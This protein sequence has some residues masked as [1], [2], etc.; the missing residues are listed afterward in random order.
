MAGEFKMSDYLYNINTRKSIDTKWMRKEK[1]TKEDREWCATNPIYNEMYGESFYQR[2]VISL[3]P[4]HKYSVTVEIE[5]APYGDGMIPM[6]GIAYGKGKLWGQSI[7]IDTGKTI[8]FDTKCLGVVL[9]KNQ[10]L[11]LFNFV[12][13]LGYM[14]VEYK[15][16]FFD[17]N[18][19]VYV[20]E[21][22]TLNYAYA[23]K[24]EMVGENKVRYF[25]KHAKAEK[26]DF[27]ALIFT[28]TWNLI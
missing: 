1:V 26:N 15:N 17:E 14:C 4:N 20:R 21:P 25:C 12:S 27:T 3:L 9:T 24:K 16:E 7:D 6:M 10:Q 8:D 19:K 23:M 2:D 11:Y 28:I 22:S 5:S 18:S 13:Q